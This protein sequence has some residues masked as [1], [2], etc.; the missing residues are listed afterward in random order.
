MTDIF[1]FKALI[2][3]LLLAVLGSLFSAMF[4]LIRDKGKGK[5]TVISLTA[6]V[7]LSITLFVMLCIGYFTGIIKPHGTT[8]EKLSDSPFYQ[9][10]SRA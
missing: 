7:V 2:I 8:S 10:N 9:V 5:Q 3:L 1:I 4:F 6:R